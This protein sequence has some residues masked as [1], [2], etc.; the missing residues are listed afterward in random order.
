M[1]RASVILYGGFGWVTEIRATVANSVAVQ[2]AAS[3]MGFGARL[4]G[5]P[6]LLRPQRL[7]GSMGEPITVAL[8]GL[9]L[10]LVLANELLPPRNGNI[11]A[12][13]LVPVFAA[14]WLLSRPA[15]VSVAVMAVG[16]RLLSALLGGVDWYTAVVQALVIPIGAW[17]TYLAASSRSDSSEAVARERRLRELS[18]LL[19]TAQQLS[20][21]L[22]PAVILRTAVEA[23]A[24]GISRP[25]RG[26]GPRAEYHLIVGEKARIEYEHDDPGSSLEGFEYEISRHQAAVGAVRSGHAALVRPDHMGG[27]LRQHAEHLGLQVIAMAPVRAGAQLHGL[28]SA[29]A[30]DHGAVDRHQLRLLE[31]LAHMTGLALVNADHLQRERLHAERMEGLEKI[32]SE[33]LNLV[34]HELRSPLTVALGYVSMLEDGSLGPLPEE[35]SS[36]LPMVS[37]KLREMEALVQQ[38]LEASRLEETELALKLELL[39]VRQLAQD[40]VR[41]AEVLTDSRHRLHFEAP[42]EPVLVEADQSR[43]ASILGNLLSNAIKYSPK[44]GDI[45]CTV[46]ADGAW[47]RVAVSDQGLGIAEEDLPRLFTRFGR[48]LTP[49]N[50]NIPGT[51]LGLYLSR[52]L[53]RQHGGDITASS[54]LGVGSTFTLVLPRR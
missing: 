19:D 42:P 51:G 6:D 54:K 30:R 14:A 44:G 16:L 31:V 20:A 5:I 10:A 35:P 8:C 27:E 29:T 38:M 18:F 50:R 53:A 26:K 9:G 52:E 15:V 25:G 28:L 23:T 48:I 49:D 1:A 36:V 40:A 21:S 34:S 11:G 3:R 41:S 37:S 12:L 43:L 2:G 4:R 7:A 13:S 46:S 47:V 39:D 17:T 22:E 33:I 24:R 45:R 32:K